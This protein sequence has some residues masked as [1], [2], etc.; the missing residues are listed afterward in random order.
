MKHFNANNDINQVYERWIT[1]MKI[2]KHYSQNTV[3]S[4]SI[5]ISYF[6]SFLN[7]HFEKKIS[8]S[9]LLDVEVQDI[10]SW[11]VY[12]K[13]NN[14]QSTSY[15]R[16]IAAIRN[17]FYYMSKFENIVNNNATTIKVKRKIQKLPKSLDVSDTNLALEESLAISKDTWIQKRDY[18][19]ILLIYG[20]GLRISEA[21]SITKNDINADYIRVLGKGNKIRSVPILESVKNAIINYIDHCPY[22]IGRNEFIFRGK[23]GRP[24]NKTVFQQQIRKIR[25]NLGLSDAITPHSFRHSF[26]T[27][28]LAAGADLRSIQELLGHKNLSTTQIYTSINTEKLLDSYS[29]FH[30]RSYNKKNI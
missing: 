24:L 12:L 9:D 16:Y 4:Y 28:L 8:R 13:N 5:D 3:S 19:I 11:I 25:Y 18:A 26:A 6:L 20:C 10:R 22:N 30:P 1:W 23:I 2:E 15:S 14:Y 17:F 21:L 29:K 7:K 27:H